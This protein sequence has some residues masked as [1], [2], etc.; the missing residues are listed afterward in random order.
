MSLPVYGL[1]MPA[2]TLQERVATVNA[3]VNKLLAMPDMKAAIQGQGVE[4]QVMTSGEFSMLIETDHEK[5]RCMMQASGA[6]IAEGC[7]AQAQAPPS[8]ILAA[9][10]PRKC[11]YRHA[12]A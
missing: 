1:F 12:V 6:S 5:W 3:G 2:G 4:T 9:C 8:S 11:A 7:A 10:K